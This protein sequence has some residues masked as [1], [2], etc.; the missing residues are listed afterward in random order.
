[1]SRATGDGI[2]PPDLRVA[3]E[4]NPP[5]GWQIHLPGA[6]TELQIDGGVEQ[7]TSTSEVRLGSGSHTL[8]VG[9]Q[10]DSVSGTLDQ[11]KGQSLSS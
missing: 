1:M 9:Y 7:G 11:D 4:G 6:P 10:H 8:V 5:R 2:T 3:L